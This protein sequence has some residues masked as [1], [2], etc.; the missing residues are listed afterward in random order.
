MGAALAAQAGALFLSAL[1]LVCVLRWDERFD[2]TLDRDY[3]WL[4]P[5]IDQ[6][7]SV[8]KLLVRHWVLALLL[9]FLGPVVWHN[10]TASL[11]LP[12]LNAAAMEVVRYVEGIGQGRLPTHT[13]AF[14]AQNVFLLQS[15]LGWIAVLFA[16][17]A[18]RALDAPR[19]DIFISYKSEDAAL[20]RRIADELTAAGWRVWFAEQQVLLAWRWLFALA[21]VSGIRDARFGLAITNNRWAASRHCAFEMRMLLWMLGPRRVLEVC[22]PPEPG[23]HRQFPK[24][25]KSHRLESDN[26]SAMLK[27]VKAATLAPYPVHESPR[28]PGAGARHRT[29]VCGRPASLSTEGWSA[30][31]VGGLPTWKYEAL[32]EGQLFVN[33]EWGVE[34]SR[35][36]QRVAQGLDDRRM[37]D[38]LLKWAPKHVGRVRAKVRGVHLLFHSGLSQMGM[39]YWVREQTVVGPMGPGRVGG[40]WTRK[41]SLILPNRTTGAMAEFLF[42]FGF[43]GPFGEYCRYAHIMDAFALSLDWE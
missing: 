32:P 28:L 17:G 15:I 35:E 14:I 25:S 4:F 42:T 26:P 36:G 29:D 41:L 16:L 39:T 10:L 30:H 43:R 2:A 33:F 12:P 21:I 40:Y 37:Y 9:A 13:A 3:H 5:T 7:V 1:I 20:A 8:I 18:A 31:G 19:F 22:A 24:L 34:T 6:S 27:F 38:A 23:P 11:G